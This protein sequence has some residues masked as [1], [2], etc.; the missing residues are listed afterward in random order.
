MTEHIRVMRSDGCMEIVIARPERKNA[1]TTAMYE[2]M[3]VA[4][5]GA[6]ADPAVRVILIRGEGDAFT[7]GN[8]LADFLDNPPDGS[9][10]SPVIR[11]M[12]AMVRSTRVIVAAVR[13]HA[14]GIGTTMLLHCD[15]VVAGE[16]ARFLMPFV[17]LGIVPEFASSRLVPDLVG[18]RR[19]S[20]LLLLGEALDAPAAQ[21]LGLV[22][23]VVPDARVMEVAGN[24]IDRLLA[25]PPEAL[26]RARRLIAPP[27]HEIEALI[28]REG[29]ELVCCLHAPE[30]QEA[31][32]AFFEKRPPDFSRFSLARH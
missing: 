9:S 2:A 8:D 26:A 27:P 16:S 7:A 11:F 24:Y 13:S 21:A 10:N 31:A 30:F 18:R 6:E 17:N 25:R 5:E 28:L 1:L 32:Q 3:A 15:L 12:L 19:A 23:E 20:A 29:E 22:S 14:V 4:I